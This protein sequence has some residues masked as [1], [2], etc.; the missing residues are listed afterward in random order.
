MLIKAKKCNCGLPHEY[1]NFLYDKCI[2][3]L[4]RETQINRGVDEVFLPP[5]MKTLKC[6][7]NIP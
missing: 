3:E 6:I 5:F 2:C 7:E 1:Y 4:C